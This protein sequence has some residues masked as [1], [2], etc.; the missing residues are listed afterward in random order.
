MDSDLVVVTEELSHFL[1]RTILGLRKVN[2][3]EQAEKGRY[4]SEY[5]VVLVA[6]RDRGSR[7][8]FRVPDRHKLDREEAHGNAFGPDVRGE[9]FSYVEVAD[10][11]PKAVP[12]EVDENHRDR[13]ALSALVGEVDTPSTIG[14]VKAG[15]DGHADTAPNPA[16]HHHGHSPGSVDG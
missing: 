12:K 11:L 8:T 1:Q 4:D 13:S 9:D 6:N 14:M 16:D 7:L 2:E 15:D 10:R 5:D 3:A